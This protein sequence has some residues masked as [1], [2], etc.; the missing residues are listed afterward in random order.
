MF[1]D[2]NNQAQDGLGGTTAPVGLSHNSGVFPPVGT[3]TTLPAPVE[4]AG[5]PET[6]IPTP[7][8]AT[9]SMTLDDLAAAV[10]GNQTDDASA[11]DNPSPAAPT[12]IPQPATTLPAEAPAADKD[13]LLDIKQKALQNLTPLVGK[14]D[15]T[16]LEKFKTT[17]MMIQASDDQ[18]LIQ[19]AYA[20]AEQ[21]T[22]EKEKAQALLDI[23]NEINYFT[24]HNEE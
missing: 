21:I 7:S 18:S 20:A 3:P 1:G 13:S 16:P 15:Q 14:L 5:P 19:A 24:Q 17:M 8:P 6:T 22:D 23:V 10:G 11:A 4:P 9:N 2:D 12:T